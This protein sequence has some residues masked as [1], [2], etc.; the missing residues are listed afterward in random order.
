VRPP[1]VWYPEIMDSQNQVSLIAPVP[2]QI[3]QD[4]FLGAVSQAL[5]GLDTNPVTFINVLLNQAVI[6]HA[7]DIFFEPAFNQIRVRFRVDGIL[8]SITHLSKDDYL[9]INSRI[10]VLAKLDTTE[11]RK[12]QEGQF[13]FDVNGEK[14]NIRI[15]AV[16]TIHGDMLVL[17]VLH[18]SSLVMNL[19]QLGFTA[20]TL[21]NYQEIIMDQSG[22]ILVCGP[23]GSGKTTTLYSTI[24]YINHDKQFN[25]MTIEDPVEYQLDGV[26]QMPV[27][28]EDGFTFAQGL[29]SILRLSPDIVLVGEIRDRETAVIAV[30]SGLTG[31]M[32]L[33]TIHASDAIGVIFRLLDL[34]I[35]PFLINSSLKGI[36]SQR[37][38]RRLCDH[39]KTPISTE[40]HEVDFF[41]RTIGRPPLQLYINKGC[42]E[43]QNLGYKGRLGIYEVLRS[44]VHFRD[45]MRGTQNEDVIRNKLISQG[46]KTLL[47]D[48]LLKA[49]LG[50]T[51]IGEILR[52]SLRIN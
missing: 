24:N 37:L 51:T 47:V 29:K 32:V 9:S 1:K 4:Q 10:K 18:L 28:E 48:G 30:E 8:Y 3:N 35:D 6:I 52:N 49:E 27:R 31:H 50:L 15:E 45:L 34:H 36:L 20:D 43:C 41:R 33:S 14:I 42:S 26:N 5:T 44:D 22:L 25:V 7:S 46:Y 39:C 23:T 19:N 13:T 40:S 12:V 38:V 11:H 21:K 17:R 16:H 2:P